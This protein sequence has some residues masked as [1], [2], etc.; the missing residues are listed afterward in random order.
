[1]VGQC[2][3][4]TPAS[5]SIAALSGARSAEPSSR[6]GARDRHQRSH[7][8]VDAARGDDQGHPDRDDDDPGVARG[9]V[10]AIE[11]GDSAGVDVFAQRLRDAGLAIGR[12]AAAKPVDALGEDVVAVDPPAEVREP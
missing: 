12:N 9:G 5:W 7:G 10:E 11:E 8:Q 4:S 3:N 2:V 1:M 6:D